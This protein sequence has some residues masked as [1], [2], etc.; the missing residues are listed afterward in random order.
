MVEDESVLF[1]FRKEAN[2]IKLVAF[3]DNKEYHFD[4]KE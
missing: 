1:T 2:K 4:R 3:A